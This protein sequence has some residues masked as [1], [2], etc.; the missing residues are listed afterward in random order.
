VKLVAQI[1]QSDGRADS[2]RKSKDGA[3]L[4]EFLAYSGARIGEARAAAWE[5]VKFQDNMIWI[6]GTKSEQSDRLIPMTA[7]LRE[8][9][10]KLKA[11]S[12]IQPR[13]TEFS[14]PTAPRNAWRPLAKSL[15][16]P[17]FPITTFA[18]SLPRPALN[19]AWTSRRS[20]AGSVTVTAGRWRCGCMAIFKSST[21][22]QWASASA[23]RSPFKCHQ[24]AAAPTDEKNAPISFQWM[25]DAPLP[26]PKRNM[27]IRGGPQ[28]IR[29]RFFGDNSTRK[30]DYSG[31]EIP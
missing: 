19:R 9:L 28:K 23:S 24:N 27:G 16:S 26:T 7:A 12:R 20:A 22:W 13:P 29:W 31:R 21:V 4:V 18:T 25:K 3:D 17:N 2:Q 11:E 10:L 8:F 30:Q 6:H 5:D 1:R 14:K 15:N